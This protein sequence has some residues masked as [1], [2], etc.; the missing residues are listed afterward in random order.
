[1][2]PS[3]IPGRVLRFKK[4]MNT[5]QNWINCCA[6]QQSMLLETLSVLSHR[7]QHAAPITESLLQQPAEMMPQH[8]NCCHIRLRAFLK[9]KE[10]K[11]SRRLHGARED[12]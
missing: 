6:Q 3:I 7:R 4:K 8:M 2:E 10:K 9:N 12:G 1:V 5:N 11:G